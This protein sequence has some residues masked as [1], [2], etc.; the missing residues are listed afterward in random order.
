MKGAV[1]RTRANTGA[2]AGGKKKKG[3]KSR[4]N[5][6]SREAEEEDAK[7]TASAKANWGPLEP[8]RPVLEPVVDILKP[9]LT[10]NVMYGLLVG[11]LVASWFGFGFTPSRSAP[12]FGHNIDM[13][14]P[15]RAAAYE[16]MWRREESDLWEWLEERAGLDRLGKDGGLHGHK[17]A[18]EPRTLEDRLR[19]ERVDEREVNEA[20]RVTKEKLRILQQVVE[21]SKHSQGVEREL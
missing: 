6:S 17:Q 10:G 18:V 16:E 3:K 11:L 20:I 15:Y 13:Y 8:V 7:R 9:A 21:K 14:G 1:S 5:T 12:T 4:A 19:E 2:N